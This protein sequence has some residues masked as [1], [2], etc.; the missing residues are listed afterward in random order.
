M[1]SAVERQKPQP[2]TSQVIESTLPKILFLSFKYLAFIQNS[3]NA[4]LRDSLPGLHQCAGFA[5]IFR[6]SAFISLSSSGVI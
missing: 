2:G 1:D 6:F 5:T 4:A 3:L